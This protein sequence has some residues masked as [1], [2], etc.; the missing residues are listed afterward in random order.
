MKNINTVTV[1]ITPPS[2]PLLKVLFPES[3]DP[4]VLDAIKILKEEGVCEAL[5]VQDFTDETLLELMSKNF[6]EKRSHKGVTIQ[7]AREKMSKHLYLS[8]MLLS[9]GYVDACIAG[10]MSP[11]TD[12]LRAGL[13]TVGLQDGS[14]T[15]SSFFLMEHAG[16]TFAFGDCA[17]IEKPTRDQLAMSAS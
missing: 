17:V 10:S 6:F 14:E 13:Q 4:R 11:S 2:R 5:S 16:K 8:G 1:D 3:H 7:E 12:V 9:H 15:M